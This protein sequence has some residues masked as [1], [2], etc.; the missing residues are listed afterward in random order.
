M[1]AGGKSR[2]AGHHCATLSAPVVKRYIADP[3]LTTAVQ[4]ADARLVPLQGADDCALLNCDLF[5]DYPFV[6]R[7][8]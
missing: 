4:R 8:G 3:V 2:W 5:I 7:T 1:S 6:R